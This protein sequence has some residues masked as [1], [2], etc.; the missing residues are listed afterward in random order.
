MN[1]FEIDSFYIKKYVYII[2]E[3]HSLFMCIKW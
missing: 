3:A 1:I 2:Y